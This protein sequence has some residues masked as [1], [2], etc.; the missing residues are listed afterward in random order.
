MLQPGPFL[1][2]LVAILVDGPMVG[3]LLLF[4]W[5]MVEI[6]QSMVFQLSTLG[7]F[8]LPLACAHFGTSFLFLENDTTS[9][10]CM[11]GNSTLTCG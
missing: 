4:A 8:K 9:Q 5:P 1:S 3:C 7:K 2:R 6:D 10:L 11:A